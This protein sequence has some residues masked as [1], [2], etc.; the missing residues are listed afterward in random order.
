MRFVIFL[1]KPGADG[2]SDALLVCGH[3]VLFASAYTLFDE[4]MSAS[5]YFYAIYHAQN[6]LFINAW[7][8]RL[9]GIRP[10]P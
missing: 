1:M 7:G 3:C 9:A 2:R 10:V 6:G 4:G 5:M 8:N